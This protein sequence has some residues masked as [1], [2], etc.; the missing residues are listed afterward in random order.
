MA[1]FAQLQFF[2]NFSSL[3]SKLD[4][5]INIVEI[6]S[7]DI[8]G[9]IRNMFGNG[10]RVRKYIGLDID[11]GPGVDVV[12]QGHKFLIESKNKFNMILSAEC[13]EHNPFWLETIEESI[14]NL[15]RPGVL[16]FS[17]ATTGRGVHGTHS[18]SSESA[19][20]VVEQWNSY[21]R[22]VSHS[23]LKKVKNRNLLDL[24]CVLINYQ[25]KDLYWVAFKFD[26]KFTKNTVEDLVLKQRIIVEEINNNY[27]ANLK[28]IVQ[29]KARNKYTSLE[30]RINV[31]KKTPWYIKRARGYAKNIFNNSRFIFP[32][33][34]YIIKIKIRKYQYQEFTHGVKRS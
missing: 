29:K 11:N 32:L 20:F 22:N 10:E 30:N 24:E 31:S 17:W 7:L 1:H 28:F 9:T 15:S 4:F 25:H 33:L 16:I 27:L 21:Y 5:E 12:A 18:Q 6:G 26:D 23:D 14:N 13:L 34:K 19:P 8:N 3:I 2:E